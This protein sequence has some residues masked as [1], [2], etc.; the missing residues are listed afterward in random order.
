MALE[1]TADALA[2]TYD[3]APDTGLAL[4]AYGGLGPRF[5]VQT[6]IYGLYA[7]DGDTTAHMD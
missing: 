2:T 1:L 7:Y 5:L 6:V 4:A 3:P